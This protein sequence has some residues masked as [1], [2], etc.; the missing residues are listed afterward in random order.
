MLEK[1]VGNLWANMRS[2]DNQIIKVFNKIDKIEGLV[3]LKREVKNLTRML[4]QFITEKGV[5]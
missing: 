5:R 3:Q 1:I 4:S 2:Y